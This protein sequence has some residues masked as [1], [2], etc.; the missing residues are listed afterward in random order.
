MLKIVEFIKANKNWEDLLT[1]PPYSLKIKKKGNLILFNYNQIESDT[2]KEITRESRGLILEKGTWRVVRYGFYRFFNLGEYGCD[3][4]DWNTATAS[5]KEDGT[6]IFLYYYDDEWH[7]GTRSTFD[8]DEAPLNNQGIDNFLDLFNILIKSYPNFDFNKLNPNYTYCLEGCSEFNKIV[9]SYDKPQLFHILTRDNDTLEELDIDIGLPKP[10][11]YI[12]ENEQDYRDLVNSFD[13]NTEGI[14]IKDKYNHRVKLKTLKYFELH[15][16][17]NNH[18]ITTEYALDLIRSGED[19]E[20]LTYFRELSDFFDKI[21]AEWNEI[22]SR[23]EIVQDRVNQWKKE[24]PERGRREFS[25]FVREI[26][27]TPV[28]WFK[29]YDGVA[30]EWIDSLPTKKLVKI[31]NIGV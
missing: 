27:K 3:E 10:A 5:R 18:N 19:V 23:V 20:L 6:L 25:E 13:S 24:N 12:L 15:R 28:L 1:A 14:V 8:A 9:V 30:K 16:A 7:V 31:F 2:L 17:I 21:R 26:A 29:A 11:Q 4:I 22:Q